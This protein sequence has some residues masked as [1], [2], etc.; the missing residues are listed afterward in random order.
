MY[1]ELTPQSASGA[2]HETTA[3]GKLPLQYAFPNAL[4][5]VDAICDLY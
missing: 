2:A 3:S 1:N 4:P 5:E